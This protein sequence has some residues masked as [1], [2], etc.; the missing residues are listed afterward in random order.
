[1]SFQLSH[2]FQRHGFGSQKLSE[3][4]DNQRPPGELAQLHVELVAG[5]KEQF[6]EVRKQPMVYR[7]EH[8]MQRVV[9]EER[10]TQERIVL[11]VLSVDD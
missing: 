5:V 1:M 3:L 8:V 9:T 4:S 7:R 6:V 2:F 10:Q 11:D